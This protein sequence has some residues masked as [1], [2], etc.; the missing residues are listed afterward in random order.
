M[1]VQ[2]SFFLTFSPLPTYI[3]VNLALLCVA[4][5]Q[6]NQAAVLQEYVA[7]LSTSS[8]TD[9]ILMFVSDTSDTLDY[10]FDDEFVAAVSEGILMANISLQVYLANGKS[11]FGS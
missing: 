9:R 1:Y 7:I 4:I 3:L 6:V 8:I 10:G 5:D 11:S 2:L